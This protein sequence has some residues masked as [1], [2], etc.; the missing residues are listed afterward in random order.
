[1]SSELEKDRKLYETEGKVEPSAV[2]ETEAGSVEDLESS[3][4]D[5]ALKLAG[6]HAHHFDEQ[7]YARLRRKIVSHAKSVAE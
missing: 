6:E 7:Y 4:G 1:M 2:I 5:D 3:D